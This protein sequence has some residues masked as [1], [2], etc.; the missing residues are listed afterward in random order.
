VYSPAIASGYGIDIG[1]KWHWQGD[2]QWH[3]V[4]QAVNR[5]SGHITVWYDGVQVLSAPD[6]V[7]DISSIPFSGVFFSTFFGGHDTTW[8]PSNDEFADFAGFAVSTTY[9]GT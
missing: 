9:I 7:K 5:A 1:G 2:G 6:V 8:G 4:E 3:M